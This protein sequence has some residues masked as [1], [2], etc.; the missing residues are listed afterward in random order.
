VQ[1]ANINYN[2][3]IINDFGTTIYSSRTQYLA[4][5]IYATVNIAGYYGLTAD[6]YS[7][8]NV[9]EVTFTWD[10]KYRSLGSIVFSSSGWGRSTYGTWGAGQYKI[11]VGCNNK[12]LYTYYF[13]IY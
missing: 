11:V 13:Y 8:G 6:L 3:N 10:E 4:L 5:K 9:Y 2:G 7:P 1:V 12:T